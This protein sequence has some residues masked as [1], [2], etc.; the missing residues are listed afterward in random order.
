MELQRTV[1][2][3]RYWPRVIGDMRDFQEIARG[4]NPEFA[5]LWDAVTRFIQDCFVHTG[6]EWAIER[7]EKIF[8][9]ETYKTDTLEQRRARILAMIT[10]QLPYTMRALRNMLEALLGAG[11]YTATVNPVTNTISVL[12]NVRIAHQMDDVR[13]L[14][15]AV[16]PAN[17]GIEIGSLYSTHERLAGYTHGEL[18]AYT[19]KYIQ[20]Q[21]EV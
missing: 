8:R 16:V 12:V 19:H 2:I 15:D 7:W 11:N 3:E 20:E 17:L 18:A 1:T 9:L 21:L 13:Q 4:E 6:T 5:T 10:R 14:L